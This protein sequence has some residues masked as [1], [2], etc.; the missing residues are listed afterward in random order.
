MTP[1]RVAAISTTPG[2]EQIRQQQALRKRVTL[3]CN[4]KTQTRSETSDGKSREEL[5]RN[6]VDTVG[7]IDWS[8]KQVRDKMNKREG[9]DCEVKI[10]DE[11][12]EEVDMAYGRPSIWEG[13]LVE[14]EKKVEE[15]S[16][17]LSLREKQLEVREVQVRE[18][19]LEMKKIRE[20]T[21]NI[22]NIIDEKLLLSRQLSDTDQELQREKDL[23]KKGESAKNEAEHNMQK[24]ALRLET[25]L[26]QKSELMGQYQLLGA[27]LQIFAKEVEMSRETVETL[28]SE[29]QK[30]RRIAQDAKAVSEDPSSKKANKV[31]LVTPE[32]L[33]EV[34]P[35]SEEIIDPKA[36]A[37]MEVSR[38]AGRRKGELLDLLR[39]QED[40]E[41]P[42]SGSRMDFVEKKVFFQKKI[43]AE[44][45]SPSLRERK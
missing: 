34:N 41:N 18:K 37:V 36:T 31:C 27:Q 26:S 16:R 44:I 11:T 32:P 13:H 33:S 39:I 42:K 38:E 15:L 1:R 6:D 7:G 4:K 23:R 9:C 5:L 35:G 21:K 25:S 43:E 8:R 12:N 14:R 28:S 45:S 2:R 29:V 24:V 20:N 17:A 10:P 22:K 30:W 40:D 19:E 3:A